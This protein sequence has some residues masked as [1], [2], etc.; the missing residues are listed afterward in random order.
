MIRPSGGSTS[1]RDRLELPTKLTIMISMPLPYCMYVLLS[2]KDRLLYIGYTTNL[3]KRIKDHNAGGTK[4]TSGRRPLRLIYC[5]FH[6]SKADAERREKYFKT[7][8][9]R[10]AIKLMLRESLKELNYGS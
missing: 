10:K 7:S 2:E 5:E 9:G 8:P 1:E 6:L 4:S 3:E